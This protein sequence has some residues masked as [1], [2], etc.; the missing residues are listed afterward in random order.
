[1]KIDF[2]VIEK[3]LLDALRAE[4][5]T[6]QR[7]DGDVFLVFREYDEFAEKFNWQH[8]SLSAVADRIARD[9]EDVK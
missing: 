5:L 1:M 2:R 3:I 6:V 8:Y 7:S 4:G 9:L